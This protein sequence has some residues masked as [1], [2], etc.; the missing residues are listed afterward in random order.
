MKTMYSEEY[1]FQVIAA[2]CRISSG[3]ACMKLIRSSMSVYLKSLQKIF[4]V[5]LPI[6]NYLKQGLAQC[7]LGANLACF[8][9][10]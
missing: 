1:T 3:K 8:L 10:L 9:F 4:P 2:Y 5:M 7:G 6:I